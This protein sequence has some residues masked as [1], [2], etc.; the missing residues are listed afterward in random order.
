MT[1]PFCPHSYPHDR[2]IYSKSKKPPWENKR[3]VTS[4]ESLKSWVKKSFWHGLCLPVQKF[5]HG[6]HFPQITIIT[7]LK[8]KQLWLPRI[9]DRWEKKIELSVIRCRHQIHKQKIE[10]ERAQL[11][12]ALPQTWCNNVHWTNLQTTHV[13]RPPFTMCLA[14][15]TEMEGSVS[16]LLHK[17]DNL[18]SQTRHIGPPHYVSLFFLFME[19]LPVF[20]KRFKHSPGVVGVWVCLFVLF[21]INI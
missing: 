12:R 8:K 3:T 19:I 1:F 9:S 20:K 7:F 2:W 18:Q 17:V 21:F 6:S 10:K 13:P 14:H 15:C 11:L 16:E 5:N 4:P